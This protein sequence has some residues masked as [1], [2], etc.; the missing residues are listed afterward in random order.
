MNSPQKTDKLADYITVA[1]RIDAFY[2]KHPLGRIITTIIEHDAASGFI[3][4][5]AEVYRTLEDTEPA[6]TGHAFEFKDAG[7]VQRTSYVEVC[8]TSAVGRAIAFLGFEVKKGV[9]SREEMQ[10]ATRVRTSPAKDGMASIS[11]ILPAVVVDPP[12][13][14]APHGKLDSDIMDAIGILGKSHD[15][16][17]EFVTKKFKHGGAWYTLREDQKDE[18]LAIMRSKVDQLVAQ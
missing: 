9:A 6:A 3:I 12:A 10:A 16:L 8:E 4:M 5:K 18:L 13:S 15:D 11:S 2:A 17:N 1:E 14:A 7:Y